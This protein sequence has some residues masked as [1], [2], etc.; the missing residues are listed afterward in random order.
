MKQTTTTQQRKCKG[1]LRQLFLPLLCIFLLA[2]TQA[3]GQSKLVWQSGTPV[4]STGLTVLGDNGYLD[5]SFKVTEANITNASITVTLPPGIDYISTNVQAGMTTTI[6]SV[7][8]TGL[9]ST[10]LKLTI[11]VGVSRILNINDI[12]SLR[13]TIKATCSVNITN[14]GLFSVV[15][16]GNSSIE[17]S[18]RM[19]LLAVQKPSV[20]LNPIDSNIY[21]AAIGETKIFKLGLTSTNGTANSVLIKLTYEGNVV[22]LSNFKLGSTAIPAANI[23][24]S[25]TT[26]KTMT[27][28]LTQT[29]LGS[30]INEV[31]KE[32]SFEAVSIFGCDRT[33][34]TE[35]QF[36]ATTNC[37]TVTCE[38][39][40][41]R[42]PEGGTLT[43]VYTNSVRLQMESAW[44]AP[45][46]T[47][48][49]FCFD[50]VT[51]GY[52]HH[53]IINTNN[54]PAASFDIEA[55]VFGSSVYAYIDTAHMYY[56]INE[57]AEIKIPGNSIRTNPY[58]T[59]ELAGKYANIRFYVPEAFIPAGA[60][61]EVRYPLYA[62][63]EWYY[64]YNSSSQRLD[65]T[66]VV[67]YPLKARCYVYY[68]DICGKISNSASGAEVGYFPRL[69]SLPNVNAPQIK[70][71]K[72]NTNWVLSTTFRTGSSTS[73]AGVGQQ[74]TEI[75]VK[76]P[77][78]MSL[79]YTN[80]ITDAFTIYTTPPV[81][82]SGRSLGNNTYSVIYTGDL[83]SSLNVKIKV[84]NCPGG[85]DLKDSV[86]IWAD[87]ISGT[88]ETDCHPRFKK[89]CFLPY[90]VSLICNDK[91]MALDTAYFYRQTRGLRD[92]NSDHYPDDG[93]KALDSEI[94]HDL[95]F[96]GDTGY[97]HVK[98]HIKGDS[99]D[100]F[101]RLYTRLKG[102]FVRNLDFL[103][104]QAEVYI[105]KQGLSPKQSFPLTIQTV[106]ST[107]DSIY[108]LYDGLANSYLLQPEDSVEIKIPFVYPGGS[109]SYSAF[110]LDIQSYAMNTVPVNP[111][112][113]NPKERFGSDFL[114]K[115]ITF[116]DRIFYRYVGN[117][118]FSSMET[119][120]S[121]GYGFKNGGSYDFPKEVRYYH[122]PQSIELRI[123]YGYGVFDGNFYLETMRWNSSYNSKIRVI[124][125]V[126]R[127][128]AAT[129]DSIYTFDLVSYY[130]Y[131]YDGS[132]PVEAGKVF[133]GDDFQGARITT[134]IIP[135]PGLLYFN[136]PIPARGNYSSILYGDES[137]V[138]HLFDYTFSYTG[139]MLG[140]LITPR[141]LT[142]NSENLS[143][144]S[145]KLINYGNLPA[146]NSWLY[147]EG[148][149]RDAYLVATSGDTIF[150]QG[151]DRRWLKVEDLEAYGQK[152]YKLDFIYTG[153]SSCA[154]DSVTIY[155]VVDFYNSNFIP[156]INKSVF[157]VN[158]KYRSER[159]KV[160]LDN[161]IS[162]V[163]IAGSVTAGTS[164]LAFR[165]PYSLDVK[166]DGRGSQGALN[167]PEVSLSV[168]A[169]QLYK[170]GS[171]TI[172]YPLGTLHPVSTEVEQ[173]LQDILGNSS[174]LNQPV[175]SVTVSVAEA[176]NRSSFM[177]PGWGADVSMNYTDDDRQPILH[178]VFT[179]ECETPLT[180]IRYQ[181]IFNGKTACGR[182][183]IDNGMVSITNPTIYTNVKL[184]YGF[185][186]MVTNSNIAER[187]FS[188]EKATDII[189]ATFVKN[190]NINTKA[191][192]P[193]DSVQLILPRQ[194]DV[195]GTVS[196]AEFSGITIGS[197]VIKG[198]SRIITFSLPAAQ[199][200]A[201]M[202]SNGAD[203]PFTYRIP[204][205]Y[206]AEGQALAM[207]PLQNI[208]VQVVSFLG[209]DPDCDPKLA[210]IGSGNLNTLFV[211][212]SENPYLVCKGI[213][214]TMEVTS[215][216]VVGNWYKEA[217]KTTILSSA[218]N[219]YKYTP[220]SQL[221]VTFYFEAKY[222]GLS[223]G[224]VP[225]TL[226]VYPEATISV[227][228]I[229]T[230]SDN[231]DLTSVVTNT[232][233]G[234]TI[235]YYESDKTTPV[236]A[237]ESVAISS[238]V[239]YYVQVTTVD[240]CQSAMT[241][242]NVT[243]NP[244]PT[245]TMTGTTASICPGT[246]FDL[247]TLVGSISTGS[248]KCYTNSACTAEVSDPSQVGSGTYY[249][250]A[251]SGDC[252]SAY[253]EVTISNKIAP[254]ATITPPNT[255]VYAG[256]TISYTASGI[257]SY[258][259][260]ATNITGSITTPTSAT[261]TVTWGAVGTGSISVTGANAEGCTG[262]ATLNVSVN[263]Q[264]APQITGTT[265]VCK[266]AS[267]ATYTTASGMSD[268]TWTVAG[269]TI[270]NGA[271]TNEITVT[272]NSTT[273]SGNQVNVKYK[274]TSGS[275]FTDVSTFGVEVKQAPSVSNILVDAL[276]CSGSQL[277]LT[278]PV[279]TTRG[280]TITTQGWLL[281]GT[282]ITMP[283]ILSATDNGKTLKY[284]A[285]CDCNLTGYSNEV[286][287]VVGTTP[288]IGTITA[289]TTTCAGTTL[290]LTAPAVTVNV[291]PIT[292]Q[293]WMLDG[294]AITTPYSPT[295][296]DNGKELKYYATTAC[297]TV[298]SNTVTITVTDKPT[299]TN[300]PT[301]IAAFCEGTSITLTTPTV[302]YNGSSKV[303]ETW[304]LAGTAIDLSTY[305]F[306]Y[307]DNGKSLTYYA[308]NGCGG[309]TSAGVTLNVA[310]QVS[311]T[312][313]PSLTSPI[314]SAGEKIN[315]GTPFTISGLATQGVVTGYQW[316]KDGVA[317]T[318]QTSATLNKIAAPGD[319][320]YYKVRVIGSCNYVE[321]NEVYVLVANDDATLKDL[322]INGKTVEGFDPQRIS[323]EYYL[324]CELDQV[325]LA[326]V[327]NDANASLSP[328]SPRTAGLSPGDN[329]FTYTVTAEDGVTTK[330]YTLN[331]IRDCYVPRIIKDLEDAIVCIGGSHTWSIEAEGQNLTYEWYCGFNRIMGANTNSIT[332]SDAKLTN[333]ERY[334]VIVR[335]DYN[336]FKS[337][338]Y[339]KRVKLW[340]ADYL[341]SH[342]RFA[343][344]PNP[345]VV[346]TT[347][348]I[349]VD[350][351]PDVTK[352]TWS[353][354][355]EGVTF[356][357]GIGKETENETW[358]TFGTLSEG[359]GSLT[360]TMDHPCGTRELTQPIVV[361]YP[362]GIEDVAANIITVYPN[363]TLG[364]LKV[365]NTVSNQIIRV[366]DVTGALKA[367]FRTQEGITTI[368][369]TGYA[370]GTYM[371][372]YNSKTYKVIKK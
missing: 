31:A 90:P 325:Q 293:G 61:I 101:E 286:T 331:L 81:S 189:S 25:G 91:G 238:T 233:A 369:L 324:D 272:W 227:G 235:R 245:L 254:T 125:D 96:Q 358:T 89:T 275:P 300:I 69:P 16:T 63:P 41:L 149:V 121:I 48:G 216:G 366:M 143:V 261:A 10:G 132:S 106:S 317:I 173:L 165:V 179:P 123:P 285:S 169:G 355:K 206:I 363:P 119:P 248:L 52:A 5:L 241:A 298:Y 136:S 57:G 288:T 322:S 247:S 120:K 312:A 128:D 159:Q 219:R 239:T 94:R 242:L 305:Q 74:A 139:P 72:P 210:I 372:Q 87:Y 182:D 226:N 50:G 370:K 258:S 118:A 131:E 323:Y 34:Q 223:Y 277:N 262:S 112:I 68:K 195:D 307:A 9:L 344:Y 145:F 80:D 146:Q 356:S 11:P 244:M 232:P 304:K 228:S 315:V 321:S 103:G 1:S 172:E 230:C 334:Y 127:E 330:T 214:K 27:I 152:N 95:Y 162:N 287:L 263:A 314:L 367:T 335:S 352:Y 278:V 98:G 368:D 197:N 75:F 3:L 20:R 246:T 113:P 115:F 29:E 6:G 8:R 359:T 117:H 38:P 133:L 199:L 67:G 86:K 142:V 36:D 147:L 364:V 166:I 176:L 23:I 225:V 218:S 109:G 181:G 141:K 202:A 4:Q 351:Y 336:G 175:R 284:S 70:Q 357:P 78:W 59:T 208:V 207:N 137:E 22:T 204:V 371:V 221:P 260:T 255:S 311:I 333:Y 231:V 200:N 144:S 318:G 252:M 15:V 35:L 301:T 105:K 291:A 124:P 274:T 39:L 102:P 201:L 77:S 282:A 138:S 135:Y 196:C 187:A 116:D 267:T 19:L 178:L 108:A 290:L 343:E 99:G 316:Y 110:T 365:L 56:R 183:A 217:T 215:T 150:G 45:E 266:G 276:Y 234:S 213:E 164:V 339:S 71:L 88:P 33:I 281:D 203:I 193:T 345:A 47:D 320:G 362:T 271:G 268:Y 342:L 7:S 163:K 296:A 350:G 198:D 220:M 84:G 55:S 153:G 114:K 188:P 332:I 283:Y 192:N 17:E 151:L 126:R 326:A 299:I 30:P 14:P 82:G 194:L 85:D 308:E 130:D 32:I 140:S 158:L 236:I 257:I 302:A 327:P 184:D 191:I 58:S 353:Y 167:D 264:G 328:M 171:A 349:K 104:D 170:T 148:N 250:R 279:L 360:V 161:S 340:V 289:P 346:G 12:V 160:I 40:I 83:W 49:Q 62:N 180:G 270:T 107:S 269:G 251:E 66:S 154:G 157:N 256:E 65:G 43:P 26:I 28:K 53:T 111:F 297:G 354:D 295:Y 237:P 51:P 348:H 292:A 122:K 134:N 306:Q 205:K 100:T 73:S 168:P 44:D 265:S 93:T 243:V 54:V 341:P 46:L 253:Q 18:G 174:T 319:R 338:V 209:F 13:I 60:K 240:G 329:Q 190:L 186:V 229:A 97:I 21:D 249:L 185:D 273:Q 212:F 155:T 2:S 361:Q 309:T 259:W 294:T 79:D 303:M 64:N 156:D 347:Y 222:D 280:S 92:S 211:T 37:E 76:L 42:L 177:L 24:P 337:S 310:Q 224:T 313:H 129:G